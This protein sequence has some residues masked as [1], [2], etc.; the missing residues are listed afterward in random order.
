MNNFNY[1]MNCLHH[2]LK[3]LDIFGKLGNFNPIL[4]R[5]NIVIHTSESNLKII[6]TKTIT[7]FNNYK[8]YYE[9]FR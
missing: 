8:I 7:K 2:S 5:I 1:L 4:S 9:I 3:S 6:I